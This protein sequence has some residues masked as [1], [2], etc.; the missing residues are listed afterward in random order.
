MDFLSE[1]VKIATFLL[2]GQNICKVKNYREIKR[3]DQPFKK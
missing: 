2:G 3:G 1:S